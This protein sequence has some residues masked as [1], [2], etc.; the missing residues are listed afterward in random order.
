M[1]QATQYRRLSDGL[2]VDLAPVMQLL[3]GEWE[4]FDDVTFRC[5][6]CCCWFSADDFRDHYNVISGHCPGVSADGLRMRN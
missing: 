6:S 5:R 4:V 1:S 2:V 3:G